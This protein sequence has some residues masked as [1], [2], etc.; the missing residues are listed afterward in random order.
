MA[1]KAYTADSA[2]LPPSPSLTNIRP[3]RATTSCARVTRP[4]FAASAAAISNGP[5]TA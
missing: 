5:L 4:A 2:S 1:K 3:G